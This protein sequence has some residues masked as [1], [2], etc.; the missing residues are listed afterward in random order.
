MTIIRGV[1]TLENEA[2]W[3]WDWCPYWGYGGDAVFIRRYRRKK[4]R[5]YKLDEKQEWL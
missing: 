2:L 3:F 1:I 5:R 4:R